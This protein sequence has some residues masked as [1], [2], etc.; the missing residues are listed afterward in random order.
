MAECW[1]SAYV[2]VL[3]VFWGGFQVCFSTNTSFSVKN[4]IT[5]NDLKLDGNDLVSISNLGYE[6]NLSNVIV[7]DINGSGHSRTV[8]GAIDM[9]P[10]HNTERVKIYIL[11][12]TYRSVYVKQRMLTDF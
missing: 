10:E 1:S 2:V 8:Q 9:V 4:Y 5:W 7:V 11:P 12:G 3:L 6:Y